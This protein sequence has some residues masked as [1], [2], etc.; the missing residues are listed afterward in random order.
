MLRSHFAALTLTNS[1]VSHR[2]EGKHQPHPE[3]EVEVK[4]VNA[5]D[6]DEAEDSGQVA[7]GLQRE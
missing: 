2:Y 1:A 4:S 3:T 5:V 7:E 6:G